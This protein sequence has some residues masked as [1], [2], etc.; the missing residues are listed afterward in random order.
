VKFDD[1]V[2]EVRR[3]IDDEPDTTP[4]DY[5]FNYTDDQIKGLIKNA[6]PEL[7]VFRGLWG[8]TIR[9]EQFSPWYIPDSDTLSIDPLLFQSSSNVTV[10]DT[11]Y[12]TDPSASGYI[13]T[14]PEYLAISA[15][16]ASE[17][18]THDFNYRRNIYYQ[19]LNSG[20]VSLYDYDG[21]THGVTDGA[22]YVRRVLSGIV[23]VRVDLVTEDTAEGQSVAV[24][25]SLDGGNT[26][27]SKDLDVTEGTEIDVLDYPSTSFVVKLTLGSS[28]GTSPKVHDMR[29]VVWQVEHLEKN[30]IQVVKL[31]HALHLQRMW[32][33]AS[34]RGSVDLADRLYYRFQQI[35][36]EVAGFFEDGAQTQKM[37]GPQV[38]QG[39]QN[40][41]HTKYFGG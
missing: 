32:D 2:A 26:W 6:I 7:P 33:R 3:R 5:R 23:T 9:E 31:A 22:F 10:D 36:K 40:R 8:R 41:Y 28:T 17:I 13:I 11:L 29:V 16:E 15:A 12:L 1:L 38:Y 30:E 24:D 14:A 19:T 34:G 20:Y 35:K 27:V 37:V 39:K 18:R 4:S 25:I 21:A